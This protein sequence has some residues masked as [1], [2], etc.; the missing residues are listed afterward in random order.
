MNGRTRSELVKNNKK[1]TARQKSEGGKKTKSGGLGITK[2]KN[3]T[4]QKLIITKINSTF[5]VS[6]LSLAEETLF[7]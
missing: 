3:R 4:E 2:K 7:K 5:K 6:L 1:A